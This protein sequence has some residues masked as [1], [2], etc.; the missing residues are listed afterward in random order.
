MAQAGLAVHFQV[1]GKHRCCA[2]EPH[3][4]E[5]VVPG[6][7]G[8]GSFAASLHVESVCAG[9]LE[10][11]PASLCLI[12][13]LVH[14]VQPAVAGRGAHFFKNLPTKLRIG[15]ESWE[16]GRAKTVRAQRGFSSHAWLVGVHNGAIL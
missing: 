15:P 9:N 1:T 7:C 2:S 4:P 12:R 5:R 6:K 14:V 13:A 11:L 16:A 10:V 8:F 3:R